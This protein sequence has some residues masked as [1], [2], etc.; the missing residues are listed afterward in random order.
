M[1]KVNIIGA[2]IAG[3][4]AGCYLQMN[5]YDTEIFELHDLPGGLCTG[6][7]R[8]GYTINGCLDWLVGS[9]P[10]DDL[11]HLWSELIDMEKLTFVEPDIYLR[12]EDKTGQTLT[13]Y[14][15][16]DQL[17]NEM[18]TKAPEDRTVILAFT[19][20]I[21]KFMKLALPVKVAPETMGFLDGMALIW[22]MVPYIGMLRKWMCISEKEYADQC[23]N[24]LL[25]KAFSHMFW[26]NMIMLFIIMT[27][28]WMH[29][30]TAGYPIGGSLKF[31]KLIEK[32]YYELGGRI[33]YNSKVLEIKTEQDVA[34]GI[35][36]E[37]GQTHLSDIV[38]S[39]AD[40]YHTIY[41]ALDGRY[42]NKTIDSL[43][44]DYETFSSFLLVSLGVARTFPDE[45][46][47]IL[48]PLDVPI[49]VDETTLC[50][51]LP[52]RIF[53]YDTSLAPEGKTVIT[54]MI[55]SDSYQYWNALKKNDPRKYKAEK[56][57]IA[58]EVI[59]ALD[60]RFGDIRS[61]IEMIDVSTPSTVMRYTNNWKG[62][63]G[64]WVWSP[65]VGFRK[66][67][68]KLPGLDNF[69]MVGQWVDTGGGLPSALMSGR[70][71]TQMICRADK[72]PFKTTK[73][74]TSQPT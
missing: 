7:Q 32:R 28:G 10:N 4:S 57:R 50:K 48:F 64:G 38:I 55:A 44:R 71:V 63:H 19:G 60:Q 27:L 52:V 61:S 62:S 42:T 67:S 49:K 12:F 54:S 20:A 59:D 13:I 29:K 22:K 11:Y 65:K 18:L 40:G 74:S 14:T 46:P 51:D 26:P 24:E 21:R 45:L 53:N 35:V 56:K 70:N 33:S 8:K 47:V 39:A 36:L 30:K 17:E 2:G 34:I 31:S 25:K 16:I 41:K 1:K 68:K 72:K 37:N 3:L 5:G 43:Y 23:Q 58:N 6:W 66:I 73:A 69:F 15:D 9:S